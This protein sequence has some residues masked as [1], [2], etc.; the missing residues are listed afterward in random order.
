MVTPPVLFRFRFHERTNF[1]QI[2]NPTSGAG[3]LF[4]PAYLG[5]YRER[6]PA[7]R[8]SYSLSIT[9]AQLFAHLESGLHIERKGEA[10]IEKVGG[11]AQF[12][13]DVQAFYRA[14]IAGTPVL[15]A[16]VPPLHDIEEKIR[17]DLQAQARR[18]WVRRLICGAAT[19]QITPP[20]METIKAIEPPPDPISEIIL[21]VAMA[22]DWEEAWKTV[23]DRVTKILETQERPPLL[24][25]STDDLSSPE[26][27]ASSE[28]GGPREAKSRGPKPPPKE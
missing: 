2:S 20:G 23:G 10:L 17:L 15:E 27:G 14:V 19:V 12:P 11:L 21:E 3:D 8:L 9:T 13:G 18:D 1:I 24:E 28:A 7:L 6:I 22:K 26:K 25:D 5:D 4:L 16:K